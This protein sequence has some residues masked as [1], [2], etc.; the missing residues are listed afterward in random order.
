ADGRGRRAA[1]S[2]GGRGPRVL[3]HRGR[4]GGAAGRAAGPPTHPTR[5][6]EPPPTPRAGGMGNHPA[7]FGMLAPLRSARGPPRGCSSM[8]EHQ[9]PKLI[10]RVRFPSPAPFDSLTAGTVT[11]GSG[12][13]RPAAPAAP[14]QPLTT[15]RR[16]APAAGRGRAAG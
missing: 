14:R 12:P 8:V 2:H 5:P 16:S 1:R 11:A 4:G 7:E 10:T 6:R 13:G 3:A 9:L 15:P